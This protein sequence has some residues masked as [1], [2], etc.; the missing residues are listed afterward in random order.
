MFPLKN[1]D[2]LH[3]SG[4]KLSW[5]FHFRVQRVGLVLSH[6]GSE[7]SLNPLMCPKYEVKSQEVVWHPWASLS[8]GRE[9]LLRP[10]ALGGG[11]VKAE[12]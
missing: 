8:G 7:F 2:L 3:G 11:G 5:D 4:E 10:V 1:L 6:W 12:Q 9:R